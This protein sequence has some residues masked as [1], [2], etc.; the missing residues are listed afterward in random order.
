[1]PRFL[2]VAAFALAV[3]IG[4]ATSA[5]AAP[6]A[7]PDEWAKRFIAATGS[8]DPGALIGVIDEIANPRLPKEKIAESVKSVTDHFA[9]RRPAFAEQFEMTR[10]GT[11]FTRYRFAIS[12]QEQFLFYGVD[13]V[14]SDASGWELYNLKISTSLSE[15]MNDPYP[16]K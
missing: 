15:L 8:T 11:F 4:A 5:R 12:Y 9:G 16:F 7:D 2:P 14:R 13:L 10:L 3:G 6:T 1:M